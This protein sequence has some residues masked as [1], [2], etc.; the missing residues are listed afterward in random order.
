[1]NICSSPCCSEIEQ[2]IESFRPKE[3]RIAVPFVFRRPIVRF[4]SGSTVLGYAQKMKVGYQGGEGAYS[5]MAATRHFGDQEPQVDYVGLRCF[6]PMLHALTQSKISHALLPIENSIAGSINESYD[7]IADLDLALVGKL[8]S[9]SII[10]DRASRGADRKTTKGVSHPVALAQCGLFLATLK[11]CH[12]EAYVD[13]ALSVKKIKEDGDPTQAAIA[14]AEAAV[15]Y[16]MPILRREIADQPENYTRMVIAARDQVDFAAAIHCKTSL[17]FSTAH[18]Q[19]ALARSISLFSDR[20]INL[21]KLESR[22]KAN[23]PFE[24]V[25]YLDI[26]ANIADPATK[27]ALEELKGMT[28]YLKVFGSYPAQTTKTSYARKS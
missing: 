21:T 20:G 27:S 7:L 11:E 2:K 3:G 14:S 26:E 23:A 13:T 17:M 22:P 4:V 15:L 1:M 8:F 18:V 25:F 28:S 10:V 9:T 19:G 24:Y 6:A 5:H 16:E 12:I